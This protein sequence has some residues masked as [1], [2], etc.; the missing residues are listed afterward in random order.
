M[1]DKIAVLEDG[2]IKEYGTHAELMA[3]DDTYAHLYSLQAEQFTR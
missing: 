3:N 1:A 2:M